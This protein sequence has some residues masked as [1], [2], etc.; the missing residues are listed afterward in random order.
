MSNDTRRRQQCDRIV[1]EVMADTLRHER[2]RKW[3]SIA[4]A[5]LRAGADR[6]AAQM[7]ASDVLRSMVERCDAQTVYHLLD[8]SPGLAYAYARLARYFRDSWSRMHAR[9][10]NERAARYAEYA[11]RFTAAVAGSETTPMFKL[12]A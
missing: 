4:Y 11:E 1:R 6:A 2:N 3:E 5:R 10:E 7:V 12:E 9:H 8:G